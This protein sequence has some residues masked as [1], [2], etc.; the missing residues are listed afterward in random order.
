MKYLIL[1]ITVVSLS[2]CFDYTDGKY[3]LTAEEIDRWNERYPCG[4][5]S[6]PLAPALRKPK[7]E[8]CQ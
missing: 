6:S 3:H 8:R 2:G 1:A 5:P 4:L 7:P